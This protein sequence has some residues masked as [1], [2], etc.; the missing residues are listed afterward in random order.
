MPPTATSPSVS[1]PAM[2]YLS[3]RRRGSA[4]ELSAN[5]VYIAREGTSGVRVTD[6]DST[7]QA[8]VPALL[9]LP[10]NGDGWKSQDGAFIFIF[11]WAI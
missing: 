10:A 6:A 5:T 4:A 2:I 9:A 1:A 7:P 3:G 8:Q 11:V